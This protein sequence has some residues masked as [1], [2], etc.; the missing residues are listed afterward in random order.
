[1]LLIYFCIFNVPEVFRLIQWDLIEIEMEA[2]KED[3]FR[4]LSSPNGILLLVSLGV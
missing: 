3:F 2:G 1:M 4:G